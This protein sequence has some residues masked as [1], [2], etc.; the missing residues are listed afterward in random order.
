MKKLL[1]GLATLPFLAGVAMAGQP[2][3]LSDLQM[4]QVTAGDV[5][6]FN[7]VGANNF[8]LGGT[9]FDNFGPAGTGNFFQ[10]IIPSL[11]GAIKPGLPV[12]VTAGVL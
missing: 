4:D 9:N 5:V 7:F 8:N 6:R 2:A 12:A 11:D 1:L 3:P 10:V